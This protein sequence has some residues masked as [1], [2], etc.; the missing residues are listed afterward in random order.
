MMTLSMRWWRSEESSSFSKVAN[1]EILVRGLRISCARVAAI[2]P[3]SEM[4]RYF[5][6]ACSNCL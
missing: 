4:L 2:F 1:P 6:I 5:S 3:N